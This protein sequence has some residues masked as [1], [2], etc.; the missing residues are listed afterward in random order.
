[1]WENLSNLV[2]SRKN[3]GRE[4]IKGRGHCRIEKRLKM[5]PLQDREE[6]EDGD[7]AGQELTPDNSE[8]ES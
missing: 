8:T 6:I 2:G 1:M 4:E 5:G 7:T 3:R